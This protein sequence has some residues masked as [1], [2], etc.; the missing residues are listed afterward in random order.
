MRLRRA[1]AWIGAAVF[2]VNGTFTWF[3][4]GPMMPVAFTPLLLLGIEMQWRT[5]QDRRDGRGSLGWIV[6]AVAVA[7][8][9]YAGFPETAYLDRLLGL[10]WALLRFGQCGR[11]RRAR[12]VVFMAAGAVTGVLLAAP[13][14]VPFLHLL[15]TADLGSHANDYSVIAA[16]PAAVPVLLMPHMLGP[17]AFAAADPTQALLWLWNF[18]G[19]YVPLPVV[20]LAVAAVVQRGTPSRPLRW[21][22]A[23]WSAAM[24]GASFGVPVVTGMVYAIPGLKETQV[25]RYAPPSW[26]LAVAILAAISIDDWLC[27]RLRW[28]T[29]VLALAASAGVAVAALASASSLIG[30]LRANAAHYDWWLVGSVAS[31]T[32]LSVSLSLIPARTSGN[33]LAALLALIVTVDGIALFSVPRLSGRR[34]AVLD[35]GSIAFLRSNLGN[36]RF[37]TLGPVAPNYSAYFGVASLNSNYLPTPRNW[38]EHIRVSLDG[39][40]DPNNFTGTFQWPGLSITDHYAEFRDRAD[41]YRAL[42]VRFVLVRAGE[43]LDPVLL[44]WAPSL[45]ADNVLLRPGESIETVLPAGTAAQGLVSSISVMI[46]ILGDASTGALLV[47]ARTADG[48]RGGTGSIS[49]AAGNRPLT[50]RLDAPLPLL[51]HQELR[52]RFT[53]SGG[54]AQVVVWRYAGAAGSLRPGLTINEAS[55]SPFKEVF[56][57]T[58]TTI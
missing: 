4:D 3:G 29:V 23:G 25:F 1:A 5:G 42:A 55:S 22:L 19:G 47:E 46:G 24:V 49:L 52:L 45:P 39:Y 28:G 38:A 48:C 56:S 44:R 27:G 40:T 2:A 8:S 17:Q 9:L 32:I 11:G 13:Y 51:A 36:Q 33:L 54:T 53:Y 18:V 26:E 35:T 50:L 41:A 6:A 16:P 12:F 34:D 31:A 30:V 37:Y 58:R 21:L 43:S 14:V 7:L 20:V 57:D 10:A 15:S